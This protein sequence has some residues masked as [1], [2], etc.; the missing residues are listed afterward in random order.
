MRL[1]LSMTLAAAVAG[2]ALQDRA[3]DADLPEETAALEAPAE[4][5]AMALDADTS[6]APTVEDQARAVVS[7]LV[8]AQAPGPVGE[9]LTGC[10]I[11]SA[12]D[13]DLATLAANDDPDA[14]LALTQS[15][16]NSDATIACATAAL[17]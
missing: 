17:T 12:S 14:T 10:I 2:C 6:D 5:E 4:V 7:P 8:Q 15:L 11:D 9:A 1:I 13:A 16:L 3:E